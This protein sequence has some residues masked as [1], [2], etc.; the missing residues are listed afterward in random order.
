MGIPSCVAAGRAR[1]ALLAATLLWVSLALGAPL[2]GRPLQDVLREFQAQGLNIIF[3]SELVTPQL[4]VLAEPAGGGIAAAR[5][6]LAA[7]GLVLVDVGA[8][9][10]AVTRGPGVA[11]GASA[12]PPAAEPAAAVPALSEIV[13]TTS[14]YALAGSEADPHVFLSQADLQALPKLADEPLRAVQRLPGSA[15]SGLSAQTHLRGGEYDEVLMVFD[16]LPLNEPFHLKNFLAP[17]SVFDAEAI[18]AIDVSSGGFTVNHGDRMSGVIDITPLT[19]PQDRYTVLGL[20]LFHLNGLSAGRFDDGRGQWLA[21]ARRSN[22]GLLA[23]FAEGDV[24]SVEYHDL[25]GRVSYAVAPGTTLLAGLL[26]S[27]D[28]ISGHTADHRERTSAR[29]Q[30]QYAWTGWQQDWADAL[31]SRLLLALTHIE[32]R[33]SGTLDQPGQQLGWL[34][35]DRDLD[36]VM[37]RLDVEHHGDRLYSR[38]GAEYRESHGKYRYR[39]EVSYLPGWPFP[40]DAGSSVARD[41][42]PSPEGHQAALYATGRLRLTGRLSA[43]AGLRW[44]DQTYDDAGG[45]EEFS[46]RINLLYDLSPR[47]R[48]RLAWGRF[49]QSQAVNELQVEDGVETFHE[50][51]RADQLIVSLEQAL[52]DGLDLRIEAYT[53]DYDHVSPHFENLFDPLQLLPELQPDRVRVAPEASRARGVEA[54]LRGRG[55]GPWSWWLGYA[56]SRVTD[57]IDG[58]EVPRSWDQRHSVNAGLRYAGRHWEFTVTDSY[59]TGWPTTTLGLAT[60]PDT[61]LAIADVGPRNAVRF[62]HYNSV[63]FRV[64]RRFALPASTL[65]AFFELTN[66]LARRNPCCT[67]YEVQ[68]SGSAVTL[69]R[70]VDYWPRLIPNLGVAWRF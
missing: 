38:F 39:S 20:S 25:L 12:A 29:Y 68:G 56:W 54:L 69:D 57:D 26:S 1:T 41:L 36:V 28:E 34:E 67:S 14:R 63:D 55:D 6:V 59:H 35:D 51:Q 65:E 5:E 62:S 13:V 52:A 66:A 3:S 70:D 21:S 18:G 16:G 7:H 9:A 19:P 44:D 37:A 43:E 17:V 64:L 27:S 58:R 46:P 61:G 2:A 47:S 50:P 42:R 24:G 31:S 15:S 22:L 49:W 4:R 48:L 11:A 23:D 33:R 45:P 8:G 32:S 10:W 60:D 53:K 40:G 30:N